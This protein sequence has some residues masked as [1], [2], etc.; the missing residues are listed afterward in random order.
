MIPTW[1]KLTKPNQDRGEQKCS[2]ED[3]YGGAHC[4]LRQLG[5]KFEDDTARP[6]LRRKALLWACE[7]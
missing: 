1:V 6:Y 2:L 4:K 7:V 5:H 3:K